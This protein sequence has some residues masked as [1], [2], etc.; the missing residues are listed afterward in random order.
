VHE[1][2]IA[3]TGATALGQPPPPTV[4]QISPDDQILQHRHPDRPGRIPTQTTTKDTRPNPQ[5]DQPE[6]TE[7]RGPLVASPPYTGTRNARQ[8]NA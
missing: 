1:V 4:T 3:A 7:R 2:H 6:R 5:H 8:Q